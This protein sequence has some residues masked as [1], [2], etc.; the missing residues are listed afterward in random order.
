MLDFGQGFYEKIFK[1]LDN[2]AV[3]MRVE[4][5]G[6]YYPIWCSREFTEMMEGTAEEFIEL[7]SGGTMNT[8]HPDDKDKI[9]YL[10]KHH[11]N[12]EGGNSLNV[13]KRTVKG[14]W[15]WVTI[16]YA[17]VEEE[18]VQYAY[19]TY[20]DAT[21][22]VESKR[23]SDAAYDSMNEQ[24]M[25]LAEKSLSVIRSNLTKGIIEEALG[26]DLFAV[27]KPGTSIEELFKA[28]YESILIPEERERF[29]ELFSA[30]TLMERSYKDN[31]PINF[32]AFCKRQSGRKCFVKFSEMARRD[33]I[34]GDTIVY[35]IET[36]YNT[37]KVNETLRNKILAQQYDMVS[38]LVSGNYGVVI[39][40]AESIGKGSIFPKERNGV[41]MDYISEEV[42]PYAYEPE[43]NKNDL[44]NALSPS[45]VR[46]KLSEKEPYVV[47]VACKIDDEV[48][49]KRFM[50]YVVDNDM[51]FY[52]L[53]K[54]DITEVLRE[55][56]AK[57]AEL[58]EALREA[59]H[60]NNAK[61]TFLS[62][63]SHDIRTPMNAII[64]F[65]DLAIK[66]IDN[67]ELVRDYISKIQVS[68][69]HLLSL[70]N[71]VLDMSRIES[72]RT[73]V[74][75]QE[76]NLSEIVH[77]LVSIIQSQISAKQ[78]EL[79]IDTFHVTNEEVYA[80]PL[81][82]NQVLIN[83]LSNAVKYT[84]AT[85]KISFRI[86]QLES[87]KE[88]CGKFEFRIKDNG[89]GMS[90]EFCKHIFDAFSR[91]ETATRSGIQGTG[92]GMAITKTIIG[93]MGG[94]IHVNSK[95]GEGS[96]FIVTLD[97][98][99]RE[100]AGSYVKLDELTGMKALVVDDDFNACNSV[101]EMLDK[102]GMVSEWTTSS[103]DA[104]FRAGKAYDDNVPYN[105]FIID[106]LMPE[107]S[108]IETVKR[109]RKIV[110]DGA[111]IVILTAYDWADV[112]EEARKAGVSGFVAKPLFMSDL[113]H[114]L[115]KA[116]GHHE[117][118]ANEEEEEEPDFTGKRILLVEDVEMNR[119]LARFVLTE[120]GL[121]VDE[122]PD[123]TDAVRMMEEVPENYYDMI[124]TDV[125]MPIMDGYEATRTIRRLD[126][127]D[128]KDI[129]IIA[130]TA[131]A[132]DE[133]KENALKAGM[134]GHIAKPLDINKLV[135]VLKK[136]M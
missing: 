122:A 133:D 118:E 79:Y 131:N 49:N 8:I 109:I 135:E 45:T 75:E 125:Q 46:E 119:Q 128:V 111:P 107:Q 98:R 32:V 36:E 56:K 100:G 90:E 70:I 13:R 33:P 113:Q 22:I 95:K 65:S 84:P 136:Y 134:N 115:S 26:S 64:G 66:H 41:Y 38:Y 2:N 42:I 124:L 71:D 17:F 57:N 102:I 18:G 97:L 60:A 12:R 78:Q 14:N 88:D 81:K 21:E 27:D 54:S 10:F 105:L 130:M 72:G 55:Q 120:M 4:E 6:R 35:D 51:R 80:D 92:L 108:G 106:M 59:E 50:F 34:T 5:D 94:D 83:I 30:E 112:E 67:T 47:D 1:S 20:F 93:L 48:Y 110:G 53:L 7:E 43:N 44:L 3:L 121:Q 15:I 89:I 117:D 74:V 132:F 25:T 63:M 114:A 62:N 99:L 68:G 11:H 76:C 82:L 58:A 40:D 96:E 129:P 91:E 61:T 37:E 23:Q 126:R 52:I 29:I 85:G 16:H 24:I 69:N 116:L 77:N 19:C 101:T 39:G 86:T 123:G 9:A 87:E 127:K 73:S 31:D 104:V 103:R 28:R